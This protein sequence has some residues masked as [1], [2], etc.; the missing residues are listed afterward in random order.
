MT[1]MSEAPVGNLDAVQATELSLLVDLEACWENLREHSPRQAD[2]GIARKDLS[3]KQKA[4]DA[5][6]G[7][8]A[9]YNKRYKPAHVPE[10]LLNTPRRLGAWCRAMRDLYLQVGHDALVPCPV[11]LLDKAYR[12]ADL[13]SARIDKSIVSR[14]TPPATIGDAIRELEALVRWC[15]A[16]TRAADAGP[17]QELPHVAR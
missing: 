16:L 1:Q 5:F 4:Y 8:L 9:A 12:W 7:R 13:I 10:L 6:R 17:L 11:N 3:A 2:V 14:T 15:E